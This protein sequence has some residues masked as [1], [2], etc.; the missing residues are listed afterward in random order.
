MKKKKPSETDLRHEAETN[1]T[2][3]QSFNQ[4]ILGMTPSIVYIFDLKTQQDVFVNRPLAGVLGYAADQTA[5]IGSVFFPADVH[6]DDMKTLDRRRQR[7][8]YWKP[9]VPRP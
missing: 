2:E 3:T 8:R 5:R 9:R 4:K 1:L 7:W 6:P